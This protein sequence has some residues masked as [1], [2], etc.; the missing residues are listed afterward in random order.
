MQNLITDEPEPSKEASLHHPA[1]RERESI[2]LPPSLSPSLPPSPRRCEIYL[3]MEKQKTLDRSI[4]LGRPRFV[5]LN[6]L[7]GSVHAPIIS[8]TPL[9]S[10]KCK[11]K[12]TPARGHMAVVALSLAFRDLGI[13]TSPSRSAFQASRYDEFATRTSSKTE[14]SLIFTLNYVSGSNRIRTG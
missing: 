8:S 12:I 10:N 3:A 7:A 6:P 13:W 4:D 5:I 11:G 14:H 9:V 2:V 1:A